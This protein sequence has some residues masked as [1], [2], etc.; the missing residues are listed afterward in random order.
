VDASAWDERYAGAGLVWSAEPNRFVAD[1][2][3]DLPPGAAYDMAAGE[4]RN[5]I[6]LAARGWDVTA[7]DFS[8]V[9]LD[10]ARQLAARQLG[11]VKRRIRWV[12]ADVTTEPPAVATYDLVLIAYLHLP[13]TERRAAVRG[14]AE[15]LRPGGT[16]LLI[17]HDSSNL[18]EG[19]GGPQDPA[20]LYTADDA[21][22]DLPDLASFDVQRA[23]RVSRPS[24]VDGTERTAWDALLR[25]RRTR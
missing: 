11:P 6:W 18:T 2:L 19:V 14:A 21:L 12:H 4:G 20:V 13:P 5:A 23:E 16:L 17:A 3:A 8:A 1:E 22:H 15:A 25:L 7:A 24:I 9:A 10:K